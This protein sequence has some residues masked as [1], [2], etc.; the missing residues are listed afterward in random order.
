MTKIEKEKLRQSIRNLAVK[1]SSGCKVQEGKDGRSYPCGTCF[2]AG[3]GNLVNEKREEYKEHNDKP[4]RINEVW[5]FLLQL[6][7][8]KY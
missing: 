4:D 6:R 3:L 2:C 8:E 5:R 1:I 7:D